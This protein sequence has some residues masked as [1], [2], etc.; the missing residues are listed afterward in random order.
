MS[1]VSVGRVGRLLDW[2]VTSGFDDSEGGIGWF[3]GRLDDVVTTLWRSWA[4]TLSVAPRSAELAI[5]VKNAAFLRS[6]KTCPPLTKA[7]AL[8]SKFG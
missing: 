5:S 8:G 1:F 4:A 6:I 3:K 2:V 7:K